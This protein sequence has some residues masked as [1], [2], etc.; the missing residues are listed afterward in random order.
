MVK[1]GID[2]S[3]LA[4]FLSLVFLIIVV[5]YVA[6]KSAQITLGLCVNV[7]GLKYEDKDGKTRYYKVIET[8]FDTYTKLVI[9]YENKEGSK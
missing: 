1:M 9:D 7:G 2:R 4:D 8:D 5:L 6:V 3:L